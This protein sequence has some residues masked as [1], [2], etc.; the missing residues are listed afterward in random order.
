MNSKAE[1][2]YSHEANGSSDRAFG[3]VFSVF[4]LIIAILPLW[5]GAQCRYWALVVSGILVTLA[6]AAPFTLA[7]LNLWWIKLGA[8]LNRITSPVALGILFFGVFL[9]IGL[10]MRLSGKDPLRL[11]IDREAKSY[12]IDRSPSGPSP[13]S[14]NDQF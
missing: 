1:H 11:K 10:I 3:L 13:E 9:P 14:L 12:W 2:Y 6:L 4:F 8:L 5:H 7:P